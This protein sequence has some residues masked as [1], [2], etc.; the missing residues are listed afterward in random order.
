[1][2]RSGAERLLDACRAALL[3]GTALAGSTFCAFALWPESVDRFEGWVR[4]QWNGGFDRL[5]SDAQAAR[6][7][8]DAAREIAA[9]E[10][11]V[12]EFGSVRQLDVVRPRAVA[13]LSRL[14][15]LRKAEGNSQKA[16]SHL[17]ALHA[18]D[19]RSALLTRDL[20]QQLFSDPATRAEG[21]RLLQG[22]PAVFG[23]G[24]AWQ[25]P[26]HAEVVAPLVNALAQD[27]RIDEARNTL[28]A[29]LAWPE[30]AW[31]SLY[32]QGEARDPML[33]ASGQPRRRAD[34]AIEWTFRLKDPVKAMRLLPPA[35]ASF[36]MASLSWS[37]RA[38]GQLE[39][40]P[41][42]SRLV[43]AENAVVRDGRV[44][45]TGV[46]DPLL[47]FEFPDALPQ[48]DREFRFTASC[49][50]RDPE[51]AHRLLLGQ[52]GAK[53]VAGEG[54]AAKSLAAARGNAFSS[55]AI[56]CFWAAKQD[57]YS[58]ER[59]L[60]APIRA[61]RDERGCATF[62]FEAS[63]PEGWSFL[64]IDLGA[65][66]RVAWEFDVAELRDEAGDAVAIDMAAALLHQAS[67]EADAIVVSGDDAQLRVQRPVGS[68]GKA[69][70]RLVGRVR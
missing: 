59:K 8:N 34:G 46:A 3:V 62:S 9:L 48:A 44:E 49:E 22:D 41:V 40:A 37:V 15:A 39:F 2:K 10:A 27:G 63:L 35:F 69:T 6:A 52:H 64:R 65:G 58:A 32:W 43:A 57:D 1:M 56:E 68:S 7:A 20:A 12:G 17:R 70:L 67:R 14:V 60:R 5:E 30:P 21:Y 53:L 42:A 61:V 54:A 24:L 4:E 66:E 31:W 36:A 11:L 55:L 25:L 18:I 47:V 45:L 33:V 23:S 13:A 19:P 28:A 16:L 51:W 29:A 38:P 50:D 26:S